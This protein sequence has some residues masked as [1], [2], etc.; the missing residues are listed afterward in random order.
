MHYNKKGT[1]GA[2]CDN[3]FLLKYKLLLPVANNNKSLIRPSIFHE[4]NPNQLAPYKDGKATCFN[5][6]PSAKKSPSNFQASITKLIQIKRSCVYRAEE[7]NVLTEELCA[8]ECP[9]VPLNTVP[10]NSEP[11]QKHRYKAVERVK[12]TVKLPVPKVPIAMP[13]RSYSSIQKTGQ[14][15][16]IKMPPIIKVKRVQT[17][18]GH[19]TSINPI[20]L[21]KQEKIF[22]NSNCTVNPIFEYENACAAERMLEIYKN[23]K[24]DLLQLA[25][26]IMEKLL[27]DYGSESRFLE[28]TGGSLL[29]LEETKDLF[30]DYICSLGLEENISLAFTENTVSPTTILHNGNKGKSKIIIGL[31]IEYRRNRIQGVLDHEIGT[32]FLR[33]YNDNL[34]VWSNCRRKHNL[35]PYMI[36]EEGF[37]ALNQLVRTVKEGG[38]PYLFKAALNYYS[39]YR[40]HGLSF[41]ELYKDLEKYIDCPKRRFRACLRVKRGVVYTGRPGGLYKDQIYLEGAV[42][43]L[44]KRKEIDFKLLYAGKIAI[45][46]VERMQKKIK[47]ADLKFPWFLKDEQAYLNALD[48]IAEFNGI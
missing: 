17:T 46:D 16:P 30:T 34:Q 37:A 2:S 5:R 10:E 26:R 35:R 25:V 8:A 11:K 47:T 45:D 48:K 15:E 33:K 18:N 31:P 36:T 20:N 22:F 14:D 28:K 38:E 32:H 43:I 27:S 21:H 13:S 7:T 6:F 44:R 12:R 24:S 9:E 3:S 4:Y 40:A 29:S 19:P 1:L 41:A 39:A 23:P 42:K